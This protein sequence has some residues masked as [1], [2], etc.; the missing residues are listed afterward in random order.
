M[1]HENHESKKNYTISW[2]NNEKHETLRFLF[3]NQ[4][5]HE[6]QMI[7][8][9]NNE[10]HEAIITKIQKI[11]KFHKRITELIEII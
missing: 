1:P 6:N 3:V 10:N 5:N 11:L 2:E 9:D 4:E 7:S 8:C